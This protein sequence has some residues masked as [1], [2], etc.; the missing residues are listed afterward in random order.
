[1]NFF[2]DGGVNNWVFI[3][4]INIITFVVT[5]EINVFYYYFKGMHLMLLE[6]C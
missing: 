6:L 5:N 1:M 3:I 4:I 2:C